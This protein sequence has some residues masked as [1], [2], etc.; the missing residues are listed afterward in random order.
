MRRLWVGAAALV[1]VVLL[2]ASPVAMA[3]SKLVSLT[4]GNNPALLLDKP[5]SYVL[6]TSV[7]GC[8]S[9]TL[10]RIAASDVTF[11]LGGRAL[12]GHTTNCLEGIAVINDLKRVAIRNG[13]ISNCATGIASESKVLVSN[14]LSFKND[15]GMNAEIANF[16][17]NVVAHSDLGL[18]DQATGSTYVNNTVVSAERGIDATGDATIAR[19]KVIASGGRGIFGGTG[20]R[21]VG[22]TAYGS[23]FAGLFL[24][25]GRI[26]GNTVVGGGSYGIETEGDPVMTGNRAIAN[27]SH[28]LYTEG[29]DA[30]ITN[31]S[32][33]ANRASGIR[34]AQGSDAV[35]NKANGNLT[36]GIDAG[37]ATRIKDNVASGNVGYGIF[38]SGPVAGTLHTNKAS[39]NNGQGQQCDPDDLCVPDQSLDVPQTFFAS[40][41]VPVDLS[42]PGTYFLGGS[43]NDCAGGNAINI[44]TSGVTLDLQGHRI[45]GKN[46]IQFAAGI[47]VSDG[48]TDVIVRNGTVSD[49]LFGVV[50]G[51]TEARIENIVA[52]DNVAAGIG[53][54]NGA[55]AV[56]NTILRTSSSGA[57]ILMNPGSTAIGNTIVANTDE[58]ILTDDGPVTIKDNYI[59]GNG[60]AGIAYQFNPSNGSTI[61]GN[62]V[63]GNG[64]V[65]I[66]VGDNNKILNNVIQGSIDYPIEAGNNNVVRRNRVTGNSGGITLG[67]GNT[68]TDNVVAGN[69]GA[70]IYLDTGTVARNRVIG[71]TGDGI[72][73][74]S[75]TVI[76]RNVAIGNVDNGID[77]LPGATGSGNV[78]KFNGNPDQCVPDGLGC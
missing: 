43:V 3:K 36:T 26:E 11:S 22:N 53:I 34:V 70:G 54:G 2:L 75:G 59:A 17:K 38:A 5:G 30:L 10:V 21:M 78:A 68:V 55:R 58:G 72:Q 61:T 77:A 52:I 7:D 66:R 64:W 1:V 27:D 15:T 44:T 63:I 37:S 49:Y 35:G 46:P 31:N 74:G 20:G 39:R 56:H 25:D 73:A 18:T 24:T 9:P 65:G 62:R 41:A 60:D 51:D 76:N 57:G 42:T 4:C 13:A 69:L 28:G 14:I 67:T 50:A 16:R 12:D 45:D 19:N 71:N 47:N 32:S 6:R 40:C 48:L 8:D 33:R 29:A 23:N